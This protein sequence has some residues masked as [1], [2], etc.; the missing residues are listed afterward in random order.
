MK[1][2]RF[3][4][5]R[6]LGGLLEF[7]RNEVTMLLKFDE[8]DPRDILAQSVE[9]VELKE[10][11]KVRELVKT[12]R[13]FPTMSFRESDPTVMRQSRERSKEQVNAY[14]MAHSRLVCRWKQLLV[15]KN[16]GYLERL[17]FDEADEGYGAEDTQLRFD[18]R[19]ETEKGGSCPDWLDGEKDFDQR[20]RL[21]SKNLDPLHFHRHAQ[22][23]HGDAMDLTADGVVDLT[24]SASFGLIPPHP[25]I[26]CPRNRLSSTIPTRSWSVVFQ[27]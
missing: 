10:V 20:A 25:Y 6:A 4:R 19:G 2:F 1:G 15:N 7:K 9:I 24:V 21:N 23:L 8:S 12:N 16:E 26:S 13:P 3:R 14:I 11:V 5:N 17:R 27:C 18:F 22:S